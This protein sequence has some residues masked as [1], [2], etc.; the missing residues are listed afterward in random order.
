MVLKVNRTRV[1]GTFNFGERRDGVRGTITGS[2][3]GSPG[4]YTVN[5]R[6]TV[7]DGEANNIS[8]VVRFSSDSKSFAGPYS[9][10]Q[11]S[12]RWCGWRPNTPKPQDCR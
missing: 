6:V 3:F 10:R 9:E 8:F 4:S 7:P 5:A 11:Q 2:V 12:E 1:T